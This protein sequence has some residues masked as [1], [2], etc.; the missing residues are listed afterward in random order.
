TARKARN[1]PA[2]LSRESRGDSEGGEYNHR[3][4]GRGGGGSQ[5]PLAEEKICLR[6]ALFDSHRPCS[7]GALPRNR[8]KLRPGGRVGGALWDRWRAARRA[9]RSPGN[10]SRNAPD[11][12][13]GY[14]AFRRRL[15]CAP[16]RGSRR[17]RGEDRWSPRPWGELPGAIADS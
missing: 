14:E 5:A 12:D 10:L 6:Y 15:R 16:T 8:E 13:R 1:R 9:R 17:P 4:A 11:S 2:I 3:A 7:K